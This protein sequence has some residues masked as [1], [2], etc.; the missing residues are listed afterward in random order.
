M[1][2]LINVFVTFN[3]KYSSKIDVHKIFENWVKIYIF[4][5]YLHRASSNN[6]LK[7]IKTIRTKLFFIGTQ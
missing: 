7:K 3:E 4:V 5:I 1:Y 2:H 6:F